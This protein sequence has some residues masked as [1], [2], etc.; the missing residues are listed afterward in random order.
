MYQ[1][2]EMWV[3]GKVIV[4]VPLLLR[5]FPNTATRALNGEFNLYASGCP[6]EFALVAL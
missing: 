6:L 4:I 5:A 3:N 2:Q 1:M